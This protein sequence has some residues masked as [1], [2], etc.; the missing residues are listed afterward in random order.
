MKCMSSEHEEV[1]ALLSALAKKIDL[2]SVE[3]PG[4][5]ISMSLNAMSNMRSEHKEVQEVLNALA[6]RI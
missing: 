4:Q 6:K 5:G 3:L 1:L 2:S